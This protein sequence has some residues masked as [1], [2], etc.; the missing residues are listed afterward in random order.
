MGFAQGRLRYIWLQLFPPR[1]YV[2]I[3]GPCV[4]SLDMLVW[5]QHVLSECTTG[6]SNFGPSN[7]SI[8]QTWQLYILGA[9]RIDTNIDEG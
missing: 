4:V 1:I 3:V 6:I 8:R 2:L 9:F 5:N 7:T